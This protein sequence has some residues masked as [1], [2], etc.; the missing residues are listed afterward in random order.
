MKCIH[1]LR[2]GNRIQHRQFINLIGQRQLNQNAVD[3]VIFVA[4]L[5]QIQKFRLRCLVGQ[6]VQRAF[7]SRLLAG[8]LFVSH[9][10]CARRVVT[11]QNCRQMRHNSGFLREGLGLRADFA[12]NPGGDLFS[13]DDCG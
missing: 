3:R 4:K 9:I 13:I 5:D 1:I 12:A 8:F 7:Q 10:D 6:F 2:G 11:H